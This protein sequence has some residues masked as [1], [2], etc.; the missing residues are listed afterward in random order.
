MSTVKVAYSINADSVIRFKNLCQDYGL[1]PTRVIEGFMNDFTFGRLD[2]IGGHVVQATPSPTQVSAAQAVSES[3]YHP[4]RGR[5]A[6][7]DPTQSNT[8]ALLESAGLPS[9]HKFLV[10]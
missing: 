7:A 2:W 5:P 4:K 10:K 6:K 8:A 9:D 3:M 1:V